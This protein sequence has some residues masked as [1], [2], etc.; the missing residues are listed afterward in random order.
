MLA[1][2]CCCAPGGPARHAA[3]PRL[4]RLTRLEAAALAWHPYRAPDEIAGLRLLADAPRPAQPL[5]AAVRSIV[6]SNPRLGT[7]DALLLA[8]RA[9]AAAR[10]QGLPFGFFCA[11][12]LQESAFAPG[13][14]SAAGAVG[15]AQ[16]TL[17]TAAAEGIDP[18]DWQAAIEGSARL[19]RRYVR[20]YDG[21]YADPYGAALAA[22]NAGPGAVATYR[23]VPPYPET[24][25][26]IADVYD[27]WSRIVRD[28]S[29]LAR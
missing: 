25:A 8:A 5:A 24:Q 15:I 17:P 13:A 1:L 18:F 28:E 3:P 19:L 2:S 6:R 21:R 10:R 11:T 12:L 26:Y 16:F 9:A 7:L 23:G 27:R 14:M 20:A 4:G 22:Y 29:P